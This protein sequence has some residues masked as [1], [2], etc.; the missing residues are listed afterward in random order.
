MFTIQNSVELNVIN[1][2]AKEKL[3]SDKEAEFAAAKEAKFVA[4]KRFEMEEKKLVFVKCHF[5]TVFCLQ[6]LSQ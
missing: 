2:S 4:E 3:L 1:T 5:D 6:Y